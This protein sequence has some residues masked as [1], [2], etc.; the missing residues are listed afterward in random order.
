MQHILI[1]ALF[2]VKFTILI[3]TIYAQTV[4]FSVTQPK[5]K[6]VLA[7]PF[8]LEIQANYL[9]GFSIYI[10]TSNQRTEPFYIKKITKKGSKNQSGRILEKFEFEILP[11]EIGITTFPSLNWLLSENNHPQSSQTVKSPQFTL[12]ILPFIDPKKRT[13]DI[14]DIYP[15]FEF[16]SWIRFLIILMAVLLIVLGILYFLRKKKQQTLPQKIL[17][18]LRP[19]DIIALEQLNALIA[20]GLWEKGELK[21]F[22]IKLSDILRYYIYRQIQI[23]APLMTTNDLLK[24]MRKKEINISVITQI[25]KILEFADLVKFA[26]LIPSLQDRDIHCS[27]V[28]DIINSIKTFVEAQTKPE[29]IEKQKI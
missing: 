7:C 25:R 3:S 28:K 17:E 6:P 29:I 5:K 2:L 20:S 12:E 10:D 8:A 27:I 13:N 24:N 18:D 1:L 4:S 22:Y 15:P 11:F 26:K 23:N 19:P 16:F 14:K 21:E 9:E